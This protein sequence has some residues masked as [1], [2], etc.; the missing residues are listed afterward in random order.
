MTSNRLRDLRFTSGA[1]FDFQTAR[2]ANAPHPLLLAMRGTPDFPFCPSAMTEGRWSAERRT[3]G[4]PGEESHT[5]SEACRAS[6]SR[7]TRPSALHRG[8]ADGRSLSAD[9]GPRFARTIGGPGLS[10]LPADG[11]SCPSG[12][13]PGLPGMGLRNPP[14]GTASG[15]AISTPLDDAL[16]GT[17][18]LPGVPDAV[19]HERSEVVHRR[20]GTPVDPRRNTG[21]PGLQRTANALRCA[22]D[23][24]LKTRNHFRPAR[25][26]EADKSRNAASKPSSRFAF[27]ADTPAPSSTML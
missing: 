26:D 14:A 16:R 13:V 7:R 9:P 19:Q 20:A 4:T 17:R 22:R 3:I 10:R 6:R 25:Q 1:R 21:V 18:P 2:A 27:C 11:S 24:S 5:P 8:F 15:P 23:T 12:G